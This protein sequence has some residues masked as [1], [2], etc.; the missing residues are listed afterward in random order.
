MTQEELLKEFLSD[1]L[2]SDKKYMKKS[3][4]EKLKFSEHSPNML[5][6][7]IKT[8]ILNKEQ[9]PSSV[10]RKLNQLFK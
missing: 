10:A 6:E 5:V 9:K 7:V 4:I 3:E 8:A 1:N 2:I